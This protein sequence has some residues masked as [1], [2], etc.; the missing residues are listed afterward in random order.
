MGRIARQV[1]TVFVTILFLTLFLG[2]SGCLRDQQGNPVGVAALKHFFGHGST[3]TVTAA[4]GFPEIPVPSPSAL[5]FTSAKYKFSFQYDPSMTVMRKG[6]RSDGSWRVLVG[7][8][9]CAICLS[10]VRMPIAI[11]QKGRYAAAYQTRAK[12]YVDLAM[13]SLKDKSLKWAKAQ[14]VKIDGV[15]GCVTRT[16]FK[17]KSGPTCELLAYFVK[18]RWMYHFEGLSTKKAWSESLPLLLGSLVS[19]QFD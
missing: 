7:N 11:P 5:S 12:L 9:T 1:G 3:G 17:A 2:F 14:S 8:S 18:D 4:P 16:E 6:L 13:W 15:W 19:L 10:V